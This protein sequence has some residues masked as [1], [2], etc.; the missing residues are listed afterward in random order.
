MVR[1]KRIHLPF[2]QLGRLLA[3]LKIRRFIFP[4]SR[5][6]PCLIRFVGVSRTAY[7]F[8]IKELNQ[9]ITAIFSPSFEVTGDQ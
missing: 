3:L 9:A 8:K 1:G 5:Y 7:F 4:Q 6:D 2:L